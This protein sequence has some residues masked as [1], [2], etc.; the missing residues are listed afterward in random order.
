MKHSNSGIILPILV[1]IIAFTAITVSSVTLLVLQTVRRN[2]II[3]RRIGCFY[4]AYA[5]LSEAV[6]NYRRQSGHGNVIQLDEQA[7][8]DQRAYYRLEQ[9]QADWLIVDSRNT[10]IGH[11][12]SVSNRIDGLRLLSIAGSTDVTLKRLKL[13][14]NKHCHLRAVVLG[15]RTVWSGHRASSPI[16]CDIKNFTLGLND[17]GS[18]SLFFDGDMRGA[19][20]SAEFI[21]DDG[22]IRKKMVYPPSSGMFFT[23]RVK[24]L[25]YGSE[26]FKVLTA[27]YD[28]LSGAVTL[29]SEER[30]D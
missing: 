7:G 28:L 21:M 23:L 22:S 26:V 18:N 12:R 2:D 1:I 3:Q 25:T 27:D 6:Y 14:W 11:R 30:G 9:R 8:L 10:F 24:G 16:E 17:R 20:V 29:L 4:A 13:S 15:G 5:G 19:S